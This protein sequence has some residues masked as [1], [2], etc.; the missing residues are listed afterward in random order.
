MTRIDFLF[1]VIILIPAIYGLVKG[2]AR[3]VI[4]FLSIFLGSLFAYHYSGALGRSLRDLFQIGRLGDVIAFIVCFFAVVFI[5]AMFGKLVRK[6]IVGVN[7]GCLDR[8]LGACV[9]GILGITVSFGL[10]FLIDS[11]LPSPKEYLGKS[12][13]APP[14]VD[15]G[16]YLFLLVPAGAEE[17]LMEQY[18]HLKKMWESEKEESSGV[19]ST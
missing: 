19:L 16:E 2:I 14:I 7:L 9:G 10:I 8:L 6:G 15:I 4:M 5:C 18:E 17:E 13:L 12:R 11:Y 1:L 3:M